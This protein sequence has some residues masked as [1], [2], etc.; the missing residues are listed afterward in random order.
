MKRFK[1]DTVLGT[2]ET[3]GKKVTAVVELTPGSA[4]GGPSPPGTLWPDSRQAG[5]PGADPR[6]RSTEHPPGWAMG[7]LSRRAGGWL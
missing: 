3:A 7:Q 2:K 5:A 6:M 4:D 1:R